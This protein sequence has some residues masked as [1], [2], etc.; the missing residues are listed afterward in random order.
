MTLLNLY[1]TFFKIGLFTIG[2]G[3]ASLPLLQESVVNSGMIRQTEFID[4][5]AISQSTP[6]PI[7]INMATF[8]GFKLA[9]IAGGFVATLGIISPSL[10]IIMIIAAWMKNFAS[11]PAV[12]GVMSGIRPAALGLIASA[13][14]FILQKALFIPVSPDGESAFSIPALLLF[15]GLALAYRLKPASPILYIVAGGALGLLIF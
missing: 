4:M 3:L 1:L 2:G 13:A 10:I 5:V 8:A 7:G 12:K 9:G 6:G 15:A 14:W 11:R